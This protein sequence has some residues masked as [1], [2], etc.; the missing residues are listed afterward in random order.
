MCAQRSQGGREELKLLH[1]MARAAP[2]QSCE[3]DTPAQQPRFASIQLHP[4][5][6]QAA[7]APAHPGHPA[8]ERA[9][10]RSAHRSKVWGRRCTHQPKSTIS[11]LVRS[12]GKHQR[13]QPH[14]GPSLAD[15]A[16]VK[17]PRPRRWV[18]SGHTQNQPSVKMEKRLLQPHTLHLHCLAPCCQGGL[19]GEPDAVP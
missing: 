13:Q 18:S 7:T 4:L 1:T 10:W 3:L 6:L 9:R 19:V 15:T 11:A 14:R 12:E 2:W 17:L 8:P 5:H 16:V